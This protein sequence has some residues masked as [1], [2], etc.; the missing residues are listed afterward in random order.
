MNES[1]LFRHDTSLREARQTN[2]TMLGDLPLHQSALCLT[3]SSKD[4]LDHCKDANRQLEEIVSTGRTTPR[5]EDERTGL[6][7]LIE[8]QSKRVKHEIYNL[9]HNEKL[10]PRQGIEDSSPNQHELWNRLAEVA[11]NGRIASRRPSEDAGWALAARQMQ[12]G[13]RRIVKHLPEDEETEL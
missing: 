3:K 10:S 6:R 13:V 7:R 9:L 11:S 5:W 12:R 1:F 4:L 2:D 8:S